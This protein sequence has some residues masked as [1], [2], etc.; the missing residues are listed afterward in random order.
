MY[1][2]KSYFVYMVFCFDGTFY[3]GITNDVERRVA[4]HNLGINPKCYTLKRRPVLLVHASD[5]HRVE[6]A[7]RWEKQL[8]G[9]SHAKKRALVGAD[10]ESIQKFAKGKNGSRPLSS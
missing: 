3:V 1:G 6:D 5:F 7:I 8:K 4:E 9:W 2:V 10:W